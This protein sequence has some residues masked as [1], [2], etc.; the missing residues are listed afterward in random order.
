M[1]AYAFLI[2]IGA[3]FVLQTLSATNVHA[4][5]VDTGSIS[6][7]VNTLDGNH[8]EP[9]PSDT[10]APHQCDCNCT[11]QPIYRSEIALLG[12]VAPTFKPIHF[13]VHTSPLT[14]SI[15]GLFK[16]PRA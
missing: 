13:Q 14:S 15:K 9:N 12:V 1:R 3:L 11:F 7:I 8:T 2:I 4:C 6:K 10:K 5:D 16:P